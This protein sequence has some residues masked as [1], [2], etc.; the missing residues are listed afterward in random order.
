MGLNLNYGPEVVVEDIRTLTRQEWLQL[1]KKGIGG[2]DAGVVYGLSKYKTRK[3]LW[4]DKM[5]LLPEEDDDVNSWLTKEFGNSLEELVAMLFQKV[6]GYEVFKVPKMFRHPLYPYML[7]DVDYFV[8][9]PDGRVF[10]L[11]CKT[12]NPDKLYMDWGAKEDTKIPVTYEWQG[13]HYMAVC[14][15]DGVFYA[16]LS[17]NKLDGFRIRFM[18]R[19]YDL[20]EELIREEGKF[21]QMVVD[22]IEPAYSSEPTD[23]ILKSIL[24]R[25]K[26][27]EESV[28]LP[29]QFAD[30]IKRYQE[31]DEERKA[32][33]RK[34]DSIKTMQTDLLLP[35]IEQLDGKQGIIEVDGVK[36]TVQQKKSS[37]K[38]IKK[39]NLALLKQEYPDLYDRYATLSDSQTI[40]VDKAA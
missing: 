35:I 31:L 16:C 19:N 28:A 17:F 39:D 21:W 25:C 36:F 15:I 20:E 30:V 8:R 37:R 38:S 14:N 34:A 11:E 6:T 24:R 29:A 7:A 23:A 18:E 27:K 2:S 9:V 13:R 3:D 33:N 32:A 40:S 26:I 12:C 22:R 1:R 5:G 4:L 10:I